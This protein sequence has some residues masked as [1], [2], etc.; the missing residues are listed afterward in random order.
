MEEFF[1]RLGKGET[2]KKAFEFATDKTEQYTRRGGAFVNT[3]NRFL[4]DAFQHPLLDDNGDG[5][6]SNALSPGGDGTL[7]RGILLGAGLDYDTNAPSMKNCS[8]ALGGV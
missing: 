5:M 2:L 6:G 7:A 3:E 4:D 1:K 8:V